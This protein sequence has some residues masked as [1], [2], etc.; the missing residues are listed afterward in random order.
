MSI[1]RSPYQPGNS[2][3]T[4]FVAIWASAAAPGRPLKTAGAAPTAPADTAA[5]VIKRATAPTL[6]CISDLPCWGNRAADDCRATWGADESAAAAGSRSAGLETRLARGF[7]TTS[8]EIGRRN[9]HAGVH[10]QFDRGECRIPMKR[11]RLCG[12][13][14]GARSGRGASV[15]AGR[16]LTIAMRDKQ[17][18]RSR[19]VSRVVVRPPGSPR[20]SW[21]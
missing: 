7:E 2:W 20:H 17:R 14:N 18:R 6:H 19:S 1:R 3:T 5:N 4:A 8:Q 21:S 15:I 12:A 10:V 9:A 13:A 16:P 11:R